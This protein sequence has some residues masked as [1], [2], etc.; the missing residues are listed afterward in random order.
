MNR[1]QVALQRRHRCKAQ[2]TLRAL[3]MVI[4]FRNVFLRDAGFQDGLVGSARF[5]NV[6]DSV[7]KVVFVVV[8]EEMNRPET[9]LLESRVA[10]AAL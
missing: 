9:F 5:R 3:K 10:F 1:R 4:G 7:G 2:T 6:V 8:S